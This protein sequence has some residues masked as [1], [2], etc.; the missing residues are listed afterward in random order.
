MTFV[1][2]CN[3]QLRDS[4]RNT[5]FIGINQDANGNANPLINYERALIGKWSGLVSVGCIPPRNA[6]NERKFIRFQFSIEGRYYFAIRRNFLMSG[7]FVGPFASYSETYVWY[8]DVNRTAS[9]SFFS[10]IGATLGYQY[11]IGNRVRLCAQLTPVYPGKFVMEQWDK[12]GIR[13]S[14]DEWP[15]NLGVFISAS[16]G[17]SF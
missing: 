3:S 4:S 16:I 9:R 8:T 6:I 11:T 17:Y 7:F 1:P 13:R 5:L 2:H 15:S 12:W 10:S 14:R